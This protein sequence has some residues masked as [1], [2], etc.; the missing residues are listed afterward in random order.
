MHQY[1]RRLPIGAELQPNGRVHFRVWAPKC[2]RVAVV[3]ECPTSD[4]KD[5]RS[6]S[7]DHELS[8][9]PD[10]Y[11]EGEFA[12]APGTRYGFRLDTGDE[13]LA[14][15]ASR[16][17]PDGPHGPSE[18]VD[19][20]QFGWTDE[21]WPGV[22]AVGLVVYEMHIGTFTE[23]GTWTA[24]ARQLPRL[25]KLG[26]NVLE[27]MPVADFP[28]RF[29]WG[30]DGVNLFAPTRLYGRPDDL[31][32]FVGR[33]H[34]LG[35]AVIL[36]VV[37]NH[38]GPSG[39]WL[40]RFADEYF[41]AHDT[42]WGR[43][44]NFDGPGSGPVREFYLSNA[45]YWIE[46][47][48]VDGLRLDATQSIV[49]RSADHI[50][51][52]VARRVREAAHGRTTWIVAEN[53][54]QHARM[55]RS[56]A[57][58]GF[59]LDALWNDDFH[60]SAVVALT[61]HRDAYYTDYF[62]RPQEFVSA[63]KH[64]FLYQG[65]WYRWQQA[66]RGAPALDLGPPTFVAFLENHDQVA[67]SAR[68]GRLHQRTSPGRYRAMT[69]LTL[70]GPWTPML[71]QGQEFGATAPF[72]YFAD[73]DPGLAEAIRQ[74]RAEFLEQF[75]RLAKPEMLRRVPDPCDPS[76]F[77][78]CKLDDKERE[79]EGP[80]WALHADLLRLRRSDPTLAAQGA[81][82]LDGAVLD[83]HAFLLRLFAAP[84]DGGADR[85]IVVNLGGDL[86]LPVLPEPLLAP[87]AGRRWELRWSSEAPEYGGSGIAAVETDPGWQLTG[88]SA[89]LL[90]AVPSTKGN[91]AR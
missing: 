17:Q 47:F 24:A 60:H 39:N 44:I 67:N 5:A 38:V 12:A 74:G 15:P 65:Q 9:T 80:M 90:A 81:H 30:Y 76:T 23:E 61:G 35:L 58:G 83:S 88:E 68:G 64:G 34:A 45:A 43:A 16:F 31:R 26:V 82:G 56:T 53:E 4:A 6:G 69:A 49:D 89:V 79:E 1:R 33:A 63:A 20:R 86:L 78:R 37:Y 48:H 3:F 72:L 14:D 7:G 28:G 22:P 85:L 46:E 18:V 11:H 84:S 27:V 54:R 42:E 57:S 70:L 36:D 32:A 59:G 75:P 91:P 52:A 10:G 19:S 71:F 77:E 40:D 73:H 41:G 13:L 8:R 62:G 21:A 50:V 55:V 51:A 29:G 87:P 66:G 2:R 25:A